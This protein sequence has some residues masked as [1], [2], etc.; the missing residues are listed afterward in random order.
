[1]AK[2]KRSSFLKVRKSR[3]NSQTQSNLGDYYILDTFRNLIAESRLSSLA[4][5]RQRLNELKSEACYSGWI[6]Y[7]HA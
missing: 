6:Q 3:K 2:M 7:S 4:S 1:M 5:A